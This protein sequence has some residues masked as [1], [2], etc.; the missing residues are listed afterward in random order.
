MQC[1]T[2]LTD[3]LERAGATVGGL[4]PDTKQATVE[5]DATKTSVQAM[6][7]AAQQTQPVHGMRYQTGLVITVQDLAKSESR[8]KS[9]LRRVR[10]VADMQVLNKETGEIAVL[11]GPPPQKLDDHAT[12]TKIAQAAAKAGLS[13]SGIEGVEVDAPAAADPAAKKKTTPTKGKAKGKSEDSPD[14][15]NPAPGGD[16]EKTEKG[17]PK[18]TPTPKTKPAGDADDKPEPNKAPEKP[19][20]KT[21]DEDKPSEAARFQILAFGNGKVYLKDNESNEKK[22]VTKDDKFGDFVVKEIDEKA[23]KFVV[24]ENPDAKE[25]IRVERK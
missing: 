12:A 1:V 7:W 14:G 22:F 19:K 21:K 24:L 17:K 3:S 2:R 18:R 5:Y 10:G 13:I 23:G 20:E 15:D 25:T 11:F 16:A 6:V 4:S 8:L 9:A